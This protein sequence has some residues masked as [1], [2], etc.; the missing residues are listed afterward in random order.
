MM[1]SR[2]SRWGTISQDCDYVSMARLYDL[3]EDFLNS[4]SEPY[5]RL[6]GPIAAA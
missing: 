2:F 6:P 5:I 3:S 1:R 4:L